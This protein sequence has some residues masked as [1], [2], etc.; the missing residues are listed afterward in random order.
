M[1]TYALVAAAL[2]VGLT[3]GCKDRDR[4]DTST[5]VDATADSAGAEVREGA[6]DVGNA[7]D[8]AGDKVGDAVR[9]VGNATEDAARQATGT[10][11]WDRRK[12]YRQEAAN[13]LAGLDRQLAEARKNVNHDATEAFTKG[14]ADARETRRH[15]GAELDRLGRATESDWTEVRDKFRASIDSLAHQLE[16]LQPDAQPM[17]GAGPK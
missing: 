2:A 4:D 6:H 14:V 11:T 9:D 15:V 7:A 5:R 12:E 17:G 13:R 10:W 1:R 3:T 16:A 8:T